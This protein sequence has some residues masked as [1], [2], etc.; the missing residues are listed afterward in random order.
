MFLH[1]FRFCDYCQRLS[2]SF[3]LSVGD[4]SKHALKNGSDCFRSNNKTQKIVSFFTLLF[5]FCVCVFKLKWRGDFLTAIEL[6]AV[7]FVNN[8]TVEWNIIV[9]ARELSGIF[10]CWMRIFHEILNGKI[11]SR[12]YSVKIEGSEVNSN[13]LQTILFAFFW[14]EFFAVKSPRKYF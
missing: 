5:Q 9:R 6:M 14:N 12:C 13:F 3:P 7:P 2:S 8:I 10:E 11:S 1:G 4:M